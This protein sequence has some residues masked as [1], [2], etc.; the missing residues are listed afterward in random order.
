LTLQ[1]KLTC[2]TRNISVFVVALHVAI[3]GESSGKT[4]SDSSDWVRRDWSKM[5]SAEYKGKVKS[6]NSGANGAKSKATEKNL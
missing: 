5:P 3:R 1:S 2:I 6:A 4:V